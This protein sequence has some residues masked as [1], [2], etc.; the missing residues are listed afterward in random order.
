MGKSGHKGQVW[1]QSPRR[2]PETV[3]CPRNLHTGGWLWAEVQLWLIECLET[4]DNARAQLHI[5]HHT[6]TQ[7]LLYKRVSTLGLVAWLPLVQQGL[8]Y[9]TVVQRAMV[10]SHLHCLNLW[11]DSHVAW[12]VFN[13]CILPEALSLVSNFTQY[14]TLLLAMTLNHYA[15]PEPLGNWMSPVDVSQD[16]KGQVAKTFPEKWWML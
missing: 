13:L 7:Q 14:W 10:T 2:P 9:S 3:S 8:K 16:L 6:A 15:W 5:S 12:V 11:L 4:R 1:G